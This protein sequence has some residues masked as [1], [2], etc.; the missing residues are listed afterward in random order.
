MIGRTLLG[1]AAFGRAGAAFGA[2][3]ATQPSLNV[4]DDVML[5]I[6]FLE[7]DQTAP[8]TLYVRSRKLWVEMFIRRYEKQMAKNAPNIRPKEQPVVGCI[9]LLIIVGLIGVIFMQSC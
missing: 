6:T 7:K 4:R 8:H 5:A 9:I 2:L 1:A 3:S